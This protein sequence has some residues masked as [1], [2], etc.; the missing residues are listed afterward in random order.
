MKKLDID[1][2]NRPFVLQAETMN[3]A[4]IGVHAADAVGKLTHPATS[5]HAHLVYVD[6]ETGERVTGHIE[7]IGLAKDAVLKLP[8]SGEQN[9]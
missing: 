3:G 1:E 7:R 4:L 5:T 2:G 8:D 9:G 6:E